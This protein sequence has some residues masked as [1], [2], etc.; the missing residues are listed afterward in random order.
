M[1]P[2]MAFGT[3][4]HETTR[5]VLREVERR[6]AGGENVLDLGC[7]SGILSI[8]SLLMGANEVLAID[9]DPLA[10]KAT[11]ENAECNSV[12]SRLTVLE[13]TIEQAKG[14]FDLVLANVE[15]R[16]LFPIAEALMN[17][18]ARPGTLVLSGLLA[19]EREATLNLYER[20]GPPLVTVDGEWIAVVIRRC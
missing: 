10:V 6:V 5:L 1:D 4:T 15:S 13:G 16:V 8:A 3:G 14:Q 17:R 19:S 2:G 7:G 18:V 20:F 12:T 11:L 9:L